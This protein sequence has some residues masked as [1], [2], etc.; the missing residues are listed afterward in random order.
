MTSIKTF[1]FSVF[2]FENNT[3]NRSWGI[4]I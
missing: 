3:Q 2:V 4:C 1:K